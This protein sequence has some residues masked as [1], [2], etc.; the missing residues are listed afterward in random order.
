MYQV[1]LTGLFSLGSS[2]ITWFVT[3]RKNQADI[4]KIE[5]ETDN[6]ELAAVDKAVKIWRE[7]AAELNTQFI[8][9]KKE[10]EEVRKEN[11]ALRNE[12]YQLRQTINNHNI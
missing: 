5:S 3:K 4:R 7:L 9:V 11:L 6:S 1:F 10:L 12:V 2:A 8:A